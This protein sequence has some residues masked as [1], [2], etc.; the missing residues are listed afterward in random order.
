MLKSRKKYSTLNA[1]NIRQAPAICE[2]SAHNRYHQHV[3]SRPLASKP[4]KYPR[5]V[6]SHSFPGRKRQPVDQA[7]V[8]LGKKQL[9]DLKA[10]AVSADSILATAVLGRGGCGLA[11]KAINRDTADQ[12][13][14]FVRLR[15]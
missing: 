12:L 7:N 1:L 14:L 13:G 11:L 6:P 5:T 9:G 10:R 15:S 8:G 2:S 3:V 4:T